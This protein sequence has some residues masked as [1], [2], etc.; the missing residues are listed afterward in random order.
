L[1]IAAWKAAWLVLFR[2]TPKRCNRWRLFLL[3][4]FG[5]TIR[6]RPFVYPSA[7]IYAPFLLTLENHACLGPYSEVYNLGPVRMK[8]Q[9]TLSQ[10]AYICN[11]THDFDDPAQPLLVGEITIGE[12]VFIGAR[13]F[14]LPGIN[15]GDYAL[16][17]ACAVVTKDV[18][19]GDVVA[20]NPARV[21]RTR[22][23]QPLATAPS[24]RSESSHAGEAQ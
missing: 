21:I 10:Q 16:V 24:R 17:A 7:R 22:R 20:G 19:P 13:A 12:D 14:I 6:G 15:V 18:A 3:R 11:G 8:T 9:A 1:R 2:S 23:K 5:A 4:L